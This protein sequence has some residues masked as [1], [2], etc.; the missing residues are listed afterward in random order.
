M[1]EVPIADV[2]GSRSAEVRAE[3]VADLLVVGGG[4]AGLTSAARAAELG[5]R[6]VLVERSDGVG[7]SAALSGGFLWTLSSYELMREE[8]PF[9]DPTLQ[10]AVID[11][12][13][14]V[15]DWARSLGVEMS[16]PMSPKA[17]PIGSGYLIDILGYLDACRRLIEK[18]DG[19][20]LLGA[21]VR[22]LI[23]DSGAV[24]GAEVA[25]RDG[26]TVVRVPS[27]VL[28]TGGFQ[29]DPESRSA[30]I[31]SHAEDL[32]LRSNP[33][34][35]G[36][37]LRLGRS[38]GAALA[39][40][41]KG[42]Y[43]HLIA[44]PRRNPFVPADYLRLAQSIYS[45]FSVIVDRRGTRFVDESV[46]YYTST[47][48]LTRVPEKRAIVIADEQVH[49]E[50]AAQPPTDGMEIVDL[51]VE[52]E[53]EGA[54]VARGATL[55]ALAAAVAAW[56]Y[57]EAGVASTLREFNRHVVDRPDGMTPPR[58]RNRRPLDQPPYF[59][60]EVEPAITF[61]HGGLRIDDQARVLDEQGEPIR[62]LLAAGV[63]GAGVHNVGY[64][65]GLAVGAVF[66]MRA[67]AV[68]ASS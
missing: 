58:S 46:G 9:G 66:G 28:A 49:V 1:K 4:M 19:V 62:G 31:G 33:H 63:D 30:H 53:R 7:G 2:H 39:D 59:A 67:A 47:Q 20:V 57:D 24:V 43:G 64:A 10:R 13:E 18:A 25:D 27:T 5:A 35:T 32:L 15:V 68:A 54:H 36:D 56:G 60:V 22:S 6:V 26:T 17:I 34:S 50:Y 44:V 52:A 55:E 61:A 48:A 14:Q 11:G 41:M 51:P 37:G 29:G 45:S 8:I 40:C 3:Y 21:I 23:T 38:V 12:Y 16:G 65:G 42:F